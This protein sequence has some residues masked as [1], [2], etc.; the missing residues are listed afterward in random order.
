VSLPEE[1]YRG[2]RFYLVV[3]HL[4][5]LVVGLGENASGES[6]ILPIPAPRVCF[7]ASARV[8]RFGLGTRTRFGLARTLDDDLLP[9]FGCVEKVGEVVLAYWALTFM[10]KRDGWG[11]RRPAFTATA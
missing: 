1:F 10:Q 4:L 8:G 6:Q 9:A 3:E 7:R 5:N 11:T 2:D